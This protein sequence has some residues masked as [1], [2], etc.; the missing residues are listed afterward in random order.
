MQDYYRIS[1]ENLGKDSKIPIK[2]LK[3][4]EEVFYEIAMEMIRAIK[5]SAAQNKECVMIIPVGPIGQ[6]PIFTRLVNEQK[7][8]LEHV[9]FINMDEYLTANKK[10]L[11]KEDKLSFRGYM[12]REVYEKIEQELL[13]PENQ[14]I[15]PDP[16]DPAKIPELLEKK[17]VDLCI[18][19]LGINGHVA[20]NEPENIS[21][22]DFKK[23]KTRIVEISPETRVV[24]S[25][26]N[27][28]GAVEAMPG[29]A[30]TIGFNEIFN[31]KK[32]RL[33]VFRPWHSAVI[34]R[35][36]YGEISSAFP[37]S[38]LQTHQDTWITCNEIAG[39][40]SF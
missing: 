18:G 10:W 37:V 2:K 7:I 30:V 25:I 8:S 5:K 36:S 11:P 28:N 14:R 24:N 13:M 21:I 9:W 23:Q 38:I 26:G 39:Q 12:E 16:C 31:A 29:F 20:F 33:Y 34:R 15:F 1:F 22:E 17:D 3:E 40:R 4:T 35:A 27:L 6:Y 32:I 19:G